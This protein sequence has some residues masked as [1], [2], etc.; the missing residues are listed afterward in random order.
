MRLDTYKSSSEAE[1]ALELPQWLEHP[2]EYTP[3]SD[4][5]AFIKKS[6]LSITATLRQLRLDDGKSSRFSPHAVVKLCLMLAAIVINSAAHNLM[7]SFVL[8]AFVLVR[9]ALLPRAAL[10]RVVAVSLSAAALAFFLGLPAIFLGQTSSALRLGIKALVS[11]GLGMEL[12]LTTPAAQLTSALRTCG[13]PNL[14]IMTIDL[15]LT[16]IVLLGDR[17]LTTLEA[18]SLRSVGKD[19]IKASS[20]G[21]VGATLLIRAS[22]SAQ[23]TYDAM[24]CRG[25]DGT[26]HKQRTLSLAP[27]D[28]VWIVLFM[29]FV[30]LALHLEGVLGT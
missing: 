13:I 11:A 2:L 1:D 22:V 7:V 16:N 6:I 24:R 27:V 30:L 26:Y 28:F 20:L 18:L 9:A 29:C 3:L 23:D 12:A 5:S 17:A 4:R 19:Q 8:L 10:A 21:G 25:F 15:A 14:V